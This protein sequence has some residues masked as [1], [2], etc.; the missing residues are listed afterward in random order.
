M[1]A[2]QMYHT[3]EQHL[4]AGSFCQALIV[5]L[6]KRKSF[7]PLIKPLTKEWRLLQQHI[8]IR[9]WFQM[10]YSTVKYQCNL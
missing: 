7:P 1:C 5:W 6:F 10:R 3:F 4:H 8:N 2:V 9:L